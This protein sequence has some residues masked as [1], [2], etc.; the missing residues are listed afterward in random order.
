[1][2]STF[3][4]FSTFP[5][6]SALLIGTLLPLENKP[7][8]LGGITYRENQAMLWSVLVVCDEVARV[9]YYLAVEFSARQ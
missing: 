4:K 9:L 5:S 2:S 6:A 8:Y 3:R 1:M 7:S